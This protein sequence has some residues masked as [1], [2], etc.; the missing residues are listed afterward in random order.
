MNTLELLQI[1]M[2]VETK[3][4]QH[5]RRMFVLIYF[6]KIR[7]VEYALQC[8]NFFFPEKQNPLFGKLKKTKELLFTVF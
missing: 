3:T 8:L 1:H 6:C 4:A 7:K 5:Y 2:H